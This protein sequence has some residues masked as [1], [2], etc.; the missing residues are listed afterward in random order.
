LKSKTWDG[1]HF[2]FSNNRSE[3]L[4]VACDTSPRSVISR[5]RP[6]KAAGKFLNKGYF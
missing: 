3:P 6:N 5:L 1:S 4:P 2:G